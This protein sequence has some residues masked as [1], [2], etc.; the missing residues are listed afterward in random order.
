LSWPLM[1]HQHLSLLDYP[2][3]ILRRHAHGSGAVGFAFHRF[4]G[5][6][7]ISL[8][9]NGVGAPLN[10][11]PVIAFSLYCFCISSCC[12]LRLAQLQILVLLIWLDPIAKPVFGYLHH[13]VGAGTF[14]PSS[15][16]HLKPAPKRL[17]TFL[18]QN[19]S[20][21]PAGTLACLE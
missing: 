18:S 19:Q 2:H 20:L 21:P 16:I 17:R 8:Y 3:L 12:R 9:L 13:E 1:E 10:F 11:W 7:D 14:K 15:P 6:C 5:L 4:M